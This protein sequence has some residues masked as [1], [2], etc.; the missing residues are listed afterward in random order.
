[1]PTRLG[2]LLIG[3]LVA[4]AP[5]QVLVLRGDRLAAAS[6]A[7]R[8]EV[9]DQAARAATCLRGAGLTASIASDDN[10]TAADLRGAPLVVLPYNRLDD[11]Q[12][13]ALAAYVASGGRLVACFTTGS[14]RLPELLG[15]A[16]GPLAEPTRPDELDQMVFEESARAALPLLPERLEQ[17]SWNAFALTPGDGTR[18]LARWGVGGRP[19]I[20]RNA[21]GCYVGHVLTGGDLDRKGRFLLAL[22][23]D[24]APALWPEVVRSAE[25]RLAAQIALDGHLLRR[26]RARADGEPARTAALAAELTALSAAPAADARPERALDDRLARLA[27]ARA[28]QARLQPSVTH[29]LRGIWI[30]GGQPQNWPALVDKCRRAG[31]NA[32]FYRVGRGGDSV[33]PSDVLPQAEWSKARDEVATGLAACHA[34]G[35]EFHAWR[36]CYHLGSAPSAWRDKLRAEGRISLDPA[37]REAPFANPAD[38]RNAALEQAAVREL[39]T[40]YDVDGLHLDYIRYTDEPSYDFDYGPVSRREFGLSLGREVANWPDE[41]ITGPLKLAYNAWQRSTIDALVQ[42]D[43]ELVTRLRPHAVLSTAVWRDP[44]IDRLAI[45]QDWP[46]WVRAGWVDLVVPM[47]YT[48]SGETLTGYV[49]RQLADAAGQARVAV[50]LGAWLLASPE[51]LLD[52]LAIARDGGADGFVLFSGNAPDLD[53]QLEALAQGATRLPAQPS[54]AAPT[55]TW[56]VDGQMPE[57]GAPSGLV[58]GSGAKLAVSLGGRWGTLRG[59]VKHIEAQLVLEDPATRRVLSQLGVAEDDADRLLL[60]G[61]MVVPSG[62]F[63]PVANGVAVLADGRRHAFRVRGPVLAG[64][65]ESHAAAWRKRQQPPRPAGGRPVVGVYQYGIGGEPLLAALAG[66]PLVESVPVYQLTAEHL[67]PLNALVLPQLRDALDLAEPT[68]GALRAWVEQGGTLVLTHDAVGYR[69]HPALFG[70]VGRGVTTERSRGVAAGAAWPGP[71]T[72]FDHGYADHVR[73]SP[74]PAGVVWWRDAGGQPV[75]VAGAVGRGRVVLDGMLT[76]YVGYAAELP[77]AELALLVGC[78]AIGSR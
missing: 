55:A 16:L 41:V 9:A 28:M 22:A 35:L 30:F 23:L 25:T 70:E 32:V 73:L 27:Q 69:Y 72:R 43:H 34:A 14:P 26:L 8:G 11:G 38:P 18:V 71:G 37:G 65:S 24:A 31:L 52:Q 61:T 6:P 42:A 5:G 12:V 10:L 63:Q 75:V 1:M 33:Y 15:L 29:E 48:T 49:T 76:G 2:L 21:A 64:W 57:R 17:D 19:A 68:A 53:R 56:Q 40:R 4:A 78:L 51:A 47:D 36:V 67:R 77:A 45:R 46:R 62:Q 74:G 50:G 13:A 39:L 54:T 44:R 7:L 59:D 58:A 20:T 3:L 60:A 66:E